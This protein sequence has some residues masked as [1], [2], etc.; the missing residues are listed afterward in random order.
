MSSE[1]EYG[2]DG[3]EHGQGLALEKSNLKRKEQLNGLIYIW[4]QGSLLGNMAT[5][6]RWLT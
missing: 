5:L 6:S 1:S 2:V 3:F 4:Q